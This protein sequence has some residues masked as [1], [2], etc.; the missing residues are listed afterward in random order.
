MSHGL[1]VFH[2]SQISHSTLLVD[3]VGMLLKMA[4]RLAALPIIIRPLY[5]HEHVVYDR[6]DAAPLIV[7]LS[8][9]MGFRIRDGRD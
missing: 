6:N 5:S 4:H 9:L 3:S 2:V 8:G 1:L 7:G